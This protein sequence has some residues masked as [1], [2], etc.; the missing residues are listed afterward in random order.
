MVVAL[1]TNLKI[2][3][4]DL[5]IDDLITRITFRPELLRDLQLSSLLFFFLLFLFSFLKP[6]HIYTMSSLYELILSLP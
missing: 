2:S 4:N 3:F 6:G 5:S 1:G